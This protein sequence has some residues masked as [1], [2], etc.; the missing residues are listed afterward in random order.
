M[1]KFYTEIKNVS[2][3]ALTFF[4]EKYCDVGTI[5][6]ILTELVPAVK[7]RRETCI[8]YLTLHT[9]NVADTSDKESEGKRSLEK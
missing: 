2:I 6:I 5:R 1:Q 7:R 8:A 3:K 9:S 4:T